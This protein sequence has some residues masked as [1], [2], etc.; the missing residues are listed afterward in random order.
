MRF[1]SNGDYIFPF[2]FKS[3]WAEH[4][5]MWSY[6]HG[7]A[8]PDGIMRLPGRLIDML[9]FAAFGNI[10]IAYFYVLTCMLIM[11]LGFFW[12]ARNFLQAH[13]LGTQLLGALFFMC[14]P[15]T[16]GYLSK[17]GLLL[18]VAML[19]I[20][21]TALKLG[22]EKRRFSYFLLAIAALNISLVHPFTFTLNLLACIVYLVYMVRGHLTFVRDNILK[23]GLLA[24]TALLLNAYLILP[25]ASLGTVSKDAMSNTVTTTPTDYTGL[26]DIANTGDIFTGLSLSKGVLKDYE[27][28]S[29]LT[30][31]LYFLGVFAFY[32]ILFGVYVHIEKRAKPQ[33]RRR[34]VIALSIFLGLLALSTA[35]FLNIDA[36][37]KFVIGL[38]GGWM[39]RSPLKWQLYM[40]LVLFTALVVALKCIRSNKSVRLLYAGLMCTFLLMNGYLFVQI[41]QRLLTPRTLGYFGAL[42]ETPLEHKNLLFIN[43]NSC[44]TFARE[45]PIVSTELNQVFLSKQTQVKHVEAG[46]VDT[47][48]LS[49]YDY[50]LG[51]QDTMQPHILTKRYS[52]TFDRSFAADTYA[53][54]KN[55]R[56]L[57]YARAVS[58]LYAVEQPLGLS[59]KHTVTARTLGREFN[60]IQA[61]PGLPSAGLQDVF[62]NLSPANIRGHSLITTVTPL[63]PGKQELH[64]NRAE[65]LSYKVNGTAID[66]S[67]SATDG[68]QPLAEKSIPMQVAAGEKITL[69]YTD[70]SFA[71]KNAVPN[72]SFEQGAWQ[73]KVGDCNAYDSSP[74]IA[75]RL[76]TEATEGK[77]SLELEAKKHTACTGPEE[78]PIMAGQHYLLHFDYASLGGR[79]G[80]Y[81]VSFN[82]ENATSSGKRLPDTKKKWVPFTAEFTAPAGATKVRLWFYAYPDHAPGKS[83][84]ARYDNVSFTRIPDVKNRFFMTGN[85]QDAS[86]AAAPAV[87]YH[88]VNPT[89][90]TVQIQGAR[91]PFYLITKET[92]NKLWQLQLDTG[93]KGIGGVL[94][95]PAIAQA[96]HVR[97][98]DAMNGWY[99]DPAA[100][101]SQDGASCT[102]RA[103]GSY[104]I[105]LVMAYAPQ[106]WFYIGCLVSLLAAAG[107]VTYVAYDIRRAR[108]GKP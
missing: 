73:E 28:Y 46:E 47:V 75:M 64:L 12:F 13:R 30:W 50:I 10:A 42:A 36:L 57:P 8:N 76:A 97:M 85:S 71:Y 90:T 49:Q 62:D 26:V 91:Q 82:D 31:P 103:D 44:T 20:T 93:S 104:D 41:H 79:Y 29:P 3:Y 7:A 108:R 22:F 81:Y 65:P 86:A 6:E 68:S 101:C 89:K 40:P 9:V 58:S 43:S 53:L 19:P 77:N 107:A 95:T 48:L 1:I 5:Y 106:R 61:T 21:L 102:A 38:P 105:R 55:S 83:G 23:F 14:N 67:R 51:C 63:Y 2:Q 24:I 88:T 66:I 80:G 11:F 87:T 25:I 33:D 32:A 74:D 72:G 17:V 60:F 45:N 15:I 78:L 52:F 16:L 92:H 56:P 4:V 99:I 27:F 37:I 54:Y 96:T 100:L 84:K 39:F 34:F 69:A 94:A 18:A 59:G 35:S 98:N 70:P